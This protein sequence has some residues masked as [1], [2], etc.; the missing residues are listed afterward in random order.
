V[1][2]YGPAD[3]THSCPGVCRAIGL[4]LAVET[5]RQVRSVAATSP[6]DVLLEA[7]AVCPHAPTGT[8]SSQRPTRQAIRHARSRK[9]PWHMAKS[10]ATGVGLTKSTGRRRCVGH[11]QKWRRLPDSVAFRYW[12]KLDG[13]G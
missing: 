8:H 9:V 10:I 3:S 12:R 2:V 7:M 4:G 13:T 1:G 6:A 5:V 11:R